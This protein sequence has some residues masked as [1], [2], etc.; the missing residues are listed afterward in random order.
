[1]SQEAVCEARGQDAQVSALTRCPSY[2]APDPFTF[3]SHVKLFS[4]VN[5]CP[6]F[7]FDTCNAHQE[8]I[9]VRHVV[10]RNYSIWFRRAVAPGCSME[11]DDSP[12]MT[13]FS[14]QCPPKFSQVFNQMLHP[15][16]GK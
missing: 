7:N 5:S 11:E 4:H 2:T 8:I 14:R 6:E 12:V 3:L 10:S 13:K 16:F 1:M 9:L 15:L